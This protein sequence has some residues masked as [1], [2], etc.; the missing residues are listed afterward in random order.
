MHV[1]HYLESVGGNRFPL[2][3]RDMYAFLCSERN[4]GAPSSRLKGFMQAVAFCRFDEIVSI[5]RCKGTTKQ[6]N[7][8]EKCQASPLF[9]KEVKIL[10]DV[11]ISGSDLWQ[12]LL[13]GAALFCLYS[14]G[15]WG[16]LMR[17]ETV[18]IDCDSS[19]VACYLEARVGSHKRTQSQQH[20]RQ[21][22]PMVAPGLGVTDGNWIE[23]WLKVRNSLSLDFCKDCVMPA[24]Q[25]DGS[26]GCRPLESQEAAGWLRLILS[27][28]A[29]P[30]SDRKVA[31]HSLK[32]TT[33][34]YAAKRGMDINLRM[35]LG[36]HTQ[37]YRLGLT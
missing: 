26:P 4:S 27:G 3:E 18:L 19:G 20:R 16:D 37:P 13:A 6:K 8:I 5:A 29:S 24:P 25:P 7:V 34:S 10:D 31:S 21:F 9:V 23:Q 12:R 2:S 35:E 14:R 36:Y 1:C 11:L 32:A 30:V 22:L 33:L 28:N 17:A 15:R